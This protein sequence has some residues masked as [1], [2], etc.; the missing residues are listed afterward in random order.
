MPDFPGELQLVAE[1]LDRL[2]V[3]GNF[4]PEELEGDFLVTA[5]NGGGVFCALG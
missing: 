5:K 4:W 1:S 3:G 2:P